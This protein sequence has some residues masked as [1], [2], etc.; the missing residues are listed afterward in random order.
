MKK[1]NFA[2]IAIALFALCTAFVTK[3]TKTTP[4]KY[5][6]LS[7]FSYLGTNYVE[8]QDLTSMQQSVDYDCIES[9]AEC[10]A[11]VSTQAT[12]VNNK[13]AVTQTVWDG[14]T[15]KIL[16]DFQLIEP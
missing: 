6:E 12:T 4:F 13:L 16:G 7:T 14:R 3:E 8:V 9:S 10:T 2:L 15:N 1:M 11:E 5:R